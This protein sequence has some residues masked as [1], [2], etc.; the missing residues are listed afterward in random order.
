MIY[1][2]LYTMKTLTNTNNTLFIIVTIINCIINT[3]TNIHT[4][5]I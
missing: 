1:C 3:F 5:V 2:N 4:N